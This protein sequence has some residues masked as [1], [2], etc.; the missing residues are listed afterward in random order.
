MLAKYIFLSIAA[1]VFLGLAFYIGHDIGV[2]EGLR[3][4]GFCMQAFNHSAITGFYQPGSGFCVSTKGRSDSEIMA[5]VAHE[6]AHHYIYTQEEH[7]TGGLCDEQRE[8]S[9]RE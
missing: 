5:T 8:K 6:M 7:F 1:I 4:E 3:K 9:I 2:E